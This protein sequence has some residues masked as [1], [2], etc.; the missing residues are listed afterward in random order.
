[1]SVIAALLPVL[2][3]LLQETPTLVGEVET[4]WNALTSATP[5]TPDQ[6]RQIDEA[7]DEAH[8]KLQGA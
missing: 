3:Q 6:Q 2:L 1:M 4:A 5:P 8:A 7:L